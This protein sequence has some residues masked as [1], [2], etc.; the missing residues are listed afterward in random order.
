[1]QTMLVEIVC[2]LEPM[3]HE[4]NLKFRS[5]RLPLVWLVYIL[6]DL[7]LPN[8]WGKNNYSM[9]VCLHEEK[10]GTEMTKNMEN[11]RTS[12]FSKLYQDFLP[13]GISIITRIYWATG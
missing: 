9:L 8:L 1:M 11:A 4:W 10:V 12:L 5:F 2:K 13:I 3:A 6:S 7:V